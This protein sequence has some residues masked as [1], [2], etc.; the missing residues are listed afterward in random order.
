MRGAPAG[1]ADQSSPPALGSV[2][3]AALGAA[4]A[5]SIVFTGWHGGDLPAQVYRQRLFRSFGLLAWDGWWYA[6]HYWLTY[7]VL[8]P[9]VSGL[10]GLP[11]TALGAAAVAAWAFDRLLTT[12]L[13][14]DDRRTARVASVLFAVNLAVPLFIG[15]VTF[16]LGEAIGL[17]AVLAFQRRHRALAALLACLAA[18]TS[19]VAG[20]FLVLVFV[21]WAVGDPTSRRPALF[22]VAA[23]ATPLALSTLL[24]GNGGTD[25]FPVRQF[26]A[27]L[28]TCAVAL[29]LLPAKERTMRWACALY[30]AGAVATFAVP[31][32]LGGNVTRLAAGFAAPLAIA[33]VR[34]GRRQRQVAWLGAGVVVVWLWVPALGALAGSHGDP[35]RNPS[36]FAP[37]TAELTSQPTPGRIEIP[38]TKQHW[39]AAYVAPKALLARGWE[40]QLDRKYNPLFYADEPLTSAAYHQWLVDNGVT[41]VALPDVPLDYS[42]VQEVALIRS[43]LPY[44]HRV[45]SNPHWTLWR[46][47]GSPG[48]VTGAARL[49]VPAPDQLVL[50][51]TRAG[52]VLVRFRY[53][54]VWQVTRGSACISRSEGGWLRV[55]VHAPGTV[56]LTAHL[57]DA[58]HTCDGPSG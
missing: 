52:P 3:V 33:L 16:L 49:E 21:A 6:G 11:L 19:P 37:L 17:L 41:W 38:F 43:G 10:I 28:A 54:P 34:V 50:H 20:I 15:Q 18:L 47:S 7:S 30:A 9:V 36:Y 51:A 44:L 53:T 24:F 25:P 32:A 42:S 40:R 5:A 14:I 26:F 39:E 31:N 55:L 8:S 1:G 2:A 22:A 57:R 56:D 46:V 27:V 58:G 29:A 4:I 35:S 12:H 48:L 23:A 13:P 45:W